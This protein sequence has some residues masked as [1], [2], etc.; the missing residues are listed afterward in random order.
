MVAEEATDWASAARTSPSPPPTITCPPTWTASTF[1]TCCRGRRSSRPQKLRDTRA[2]LLRHFADKP[3]VPPLA[4]TLTDAHLEE[5]TSRY[6]DVGYDYEETEPE[7]D[8]PEDNPPIADDD[9]G[10]DQD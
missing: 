1:R 5:L 4:L 2:A 8:E 6:W 9:T 10:D 3:F 7:P